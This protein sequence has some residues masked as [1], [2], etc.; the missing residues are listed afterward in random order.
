LTMG[1][2]LVDYM[3]DGWISYAISERSVLLGRLA[4]DQMVRLLNGDNEGA[5]ARWEIRFLGFEGVPEDI[6]RFLEEESDNHWSPPGYEP[7]GY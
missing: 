4:M 6:N 7:K 2:E 1:R 3:K 5:P